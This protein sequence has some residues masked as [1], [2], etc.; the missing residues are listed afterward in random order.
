[1]YSFIFKILGLSLEQPS[2]AV[3][4]SRIRVNHHSI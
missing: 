1:M 2:L 3:V 4:T